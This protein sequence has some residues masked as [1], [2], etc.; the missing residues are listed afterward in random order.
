VNLLPLY[1][2]PAYR[3]RVRRQLQPDAMRMF[4]LAQLRPLLAR[5]HALVTARLL[6]LLA[7]L[8]PDP[9][10]TDADEAERL[11]VELQRIAN[12]FAKELRPR[13][14]RALARQVFE[15]TSDFQRDQ[16]FKQ[17]KGTIG[18]DPL[19]RDR[20]LETRAQDFIAANVDLI[21]TV[22]ERYFSSIGEVVEE[23]VRSGQRAGSMAADIEE[24]YGVAETNAKRIANDQIG[25]L[26]GQLNESRMSELGITRFVWRT[27]EDNRVRDSHSALDGQTFAW[28]DPPED[29]KT[30]E[31]VIPGEAVNCRCIA[32]PVFDDLI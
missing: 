14:L 9:Q 25:K 30:G 23:G 13:R 20:G 27:V 7:E 28:D 31:K 18:I 29:Y 1:R 19:L 26:Y 16:L 4:Y 10:R 21:K 2:I 12:D 24:R 32:D 22:P 15:R 17:I 8:L 5:M 3:P 11:K 6:P